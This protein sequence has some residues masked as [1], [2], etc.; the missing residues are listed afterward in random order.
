MK[1]HIYCPVCGIVDRKSKHKHF[2]DDH[3]STFGETAYVVAYVPVILP[4]SALESE[5]TRLIYSEL[6]ECFKDE[7][8]PLDGDI[9]WLFYDMV[10]SIK[11]ITF[12][13]EIESENVK[14]EVY[15]K[16]NEKFQFRE[17]E[18]SNG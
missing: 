15:R 7:I 10:V 12:N 2:S 13:S 18:P 8:H 3:R 4:A 11:N 14:V 16:F 9:F 6:F 5:K 1:I 17:N